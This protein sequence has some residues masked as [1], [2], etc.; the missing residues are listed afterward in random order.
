MAKQQHHDATTPTKHSDHTQL[1]GTVTRAEFW[2][3]GNLRMQHL[4]PAKHNAAANS[5]LAVHG[6]VPNL[7]CCF[8]KTRRVPWIFVTEVCSLLVGGRS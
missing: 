6:R 7:V 1:G 8:R 5:E 2:W 4:G 3:I